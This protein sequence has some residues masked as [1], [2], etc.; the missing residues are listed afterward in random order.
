MTFDKSYLLSPAS[1]CTAKDMVTRFRVFSVFC[2]CND[3]VA[4]AGRAVQ[5]V[6]IFYTKS[7]ASPAVF[8]FT[9]HAST[10]RTV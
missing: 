4:A 1:D 2:G 8:C 5:H 10:R 7:V 6:A 9:L 3:C